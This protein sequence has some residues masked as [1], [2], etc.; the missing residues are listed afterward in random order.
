MNFIGGMDVW[1]QLFLAGT[2]DEGE[3]SNS[4]SDHFKNE[5]KPQ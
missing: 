5:E 1:L 2:L 4:W 3:L